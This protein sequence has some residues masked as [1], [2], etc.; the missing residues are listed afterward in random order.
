[1]LS[2]LADSAS[3]R[4]SPFPAG[5]L[6]FA[7]MPG[8]HMANDGA[9]LTQPLISA[10]SHL[11]DA[12]RGVLKSVASRCHKPSHCCP[13]FEGTRAGYKLNSKEKL[14]RYLGLQPQ[15]ST[16]HKI[17]CIE[18][19]LDSGYAHHEISKKQTLVVFVIMWRETR[20]PLQKD[21]TQLAL[22]I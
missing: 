14:T 9:G 16:S 5:L 8:F 12:S 22:V 3:F 18:H 6:C 2:R 17:S 4:G 11:D 7:S 13:H 15:N 10:T 21:G 19:R 1:M 20:M